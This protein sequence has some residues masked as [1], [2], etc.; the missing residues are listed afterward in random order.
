MHDELTF[1]DLDLFD[2]LGPVAVA[3]DY[4]PAYWDPEDGLVHGTDPNEPRE[5]PPQWDEGWDDPASAA[6]I[7][8]A[9][10]VDDARLFGL[11]DAPADSPSI[12]EFLEAVAPVEAEEELLTLIENMLGATPEELQEVAA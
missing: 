2:D 12:D 4:A 3:H 11:A 6:A 7:L 8:S 5:A 9:T 10:V 1:D